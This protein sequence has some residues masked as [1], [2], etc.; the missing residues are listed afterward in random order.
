M[1]SVEARLI[2]Y[3]RL[4][5][6]KNMAIDE[7]L[8]SYYEKTKTPA[9][10]IYGWREPAITV[11]RYQEAGCLDIKACREDGVDVVRRITGGGAIFH[12][13]EVTYSLVCSE[14]DLGSGRLSVKQSFERL[15]SYLIN[16]YGE[17]GLKAR[18]SRELPVKRS[19]NSSFC[20]S[21]REEF[22]I[23]VDGKKIGGNA[24]R[25][26]RGVI[27]QHGSI[28]L[29]LNRGKI[30]K[31]FC[32]AID[33]TGFTSLSEALCRKE[34]FSAVARSLADS[35]EKTFEF[36]LSVGEIDSRETG[37][38]NS[39]L[40]QKYLHDRWN[41]E[42]KLDEPSS[43]GAGAAHQEDRFSFNA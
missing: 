20:F 33:R 25:R 14:S 21:G 42:A 10:R 2:P 36:R 3:S 35:Y 37:I 18:Y 30:Q 22:D 17:F 32:G 43:T 1:G 7:Y 40:K 12:Y 19:T 34:D 11:G 26:L 38:I 15:N 13:D 27:F 31:Y 5:G 16:L 9:L 23:L 29:T 8:I 4:R 24:Q 41:I 39:L 6:F 28:P